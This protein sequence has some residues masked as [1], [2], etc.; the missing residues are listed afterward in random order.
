MCGAGLWYR[1]GPGI[2]RNPAGRNLRGN[3][4][5]SG[6]LTEAIRLFPRPV[7]RPD[8]LRSRRRRAAPVAAV[9]R[10][11]GDRV[12]RRGDGRDLGAAGHPACRTRV[13]RLGSRRRRSGAALAVRGTDAGAHPA[14]G[15]GVDA[16]GGRCTVAALGNLGRKMPPRVATPMLAFAAG[17]GFSVVRPG[18]AAGAV[19]GLALAV[20]GAAGAAYYASAGHPSGAS[21]AAGKF[22]GEHRTGAKV[23]QIPTPARD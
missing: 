23:T 1:F 15:V 19:V 2:H 8:G 17:L 14:G 5:R 16:S 20:T 12:Q 9:P 18:F 21:V 7:R 11:V 13:D 10:S 6:H 4:F 3:L 22:P